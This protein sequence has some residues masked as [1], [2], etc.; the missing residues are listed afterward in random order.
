MIVDVEALSMATKKAN[1][2]TVR[3]TRGLDWLNEGETVELD[4]EPWIQDQLNVGYLVE[5]DAAGAVV[6][7][8]ADS[9]VPDN[10]SS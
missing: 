9:G 7:Q 6:E 2:V 1:R 8:K 4:R 3:A 10:G 5:V